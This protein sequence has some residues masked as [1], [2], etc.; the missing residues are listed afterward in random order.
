M[1][2]QQEKS[3]KGA[4]DI[5]FIDNTDDVNKIFSTKPQIK[6]SRL[7]LLPEQINILEINF[8]VDNKPSAS[9]KRYI[10]NSLGIPV[11]NVQIWFQNRRAKDKS[12]ITDQKVKQSPYSIYGDQIISGINKNTYVYQH[13]HVVPQCIPRNIPETVVEPSKV[14]SFYQNTDHNDS[15]IKENLKCTNKKHNYEFSSDSYINCDKNSQKMKKR[16][17]NSDSNT[18]M[19]EKPFK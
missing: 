15:I 6:R 8:R 13:S 7:K 17:F 1:K 2:Q 3:I 9:T 18:F 4:K 10:A 12:T 14:V 16:V 5:R 19:E 11:K